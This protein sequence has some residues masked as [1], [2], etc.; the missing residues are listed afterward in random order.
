MKKAVN[1]T[2]FLRVIIIKMTMIEVREIRTKFE[3]GHI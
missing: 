3:M 2:T 1:T